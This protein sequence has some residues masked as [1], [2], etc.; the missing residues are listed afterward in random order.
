[1]YLSVYLYSFFLCVY[2]YMYCGL[3]FEV[4]KFKERIDLV[5]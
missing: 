2:M 1:M 4:E 3:N 5:V